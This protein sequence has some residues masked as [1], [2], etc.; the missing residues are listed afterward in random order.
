MSKYVKTIDLHIP[1]VYDSKHKW[2]IWETYEG[3]KVF[4][5]SKVYFM[6][7]FDNTFRYYKRYLNQ[8][9]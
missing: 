8:Y 5:I 1:E 4:N 9:C 2:F 3:D 6:I 7:K